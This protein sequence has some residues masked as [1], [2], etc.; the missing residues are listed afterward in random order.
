MPSPFSVLGS[1]TTYHP[2]NHRTK[3][4]EEEKQVHGREQVC[5][6]PKAN[7]P[8]SVFPGSTRLGT[9]R[10]HTRHQLTAWI[11]QTCPIWDERKDAH[12]GVKKG[13]STKTKESSGYPVF[14]PHTVEKPRGN[15]HHPFFRL[16]RRRRLWIL[17]FM[18]EKCNPRSQ[19]SGFCGEAW[20]NPHQKSPPGEHSLLS[21]CWGVRP[22]FPCTTPEPTISFSA[23][24]LSSFRSALAPRVPSHNTTHTPSPKTRSRV[25]LLVLD[26]VGSPMQGRECPLCS[27]LGTVRFLQMRGA[28]G[29]LTP[30]QQH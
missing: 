30:T 16:L 29:V 28:V 12:T 15:S 1:L 19:R 26:M 20:N 23:P 25:A 5:N 4:S 8:I 10:T 2:E 17:N 21:S 6:H 14:D 22:V 7:Q 27:G 11:P 13:E 3:R 24:S 9:A 18:G